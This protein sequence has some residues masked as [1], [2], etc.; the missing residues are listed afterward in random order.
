[1]ASGALPRNIRY[2]FRC[3]ICGD[4]FTL[5]ADGASAEGGWTREENRREN[6]TGE[7]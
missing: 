6:F 7:S 1:V 2:R 5:H 3:E 4:H